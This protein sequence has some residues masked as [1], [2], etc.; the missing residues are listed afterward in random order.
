[1]KKKVFDLRLYTEA[2]RQLRSFVIFSLLPLLFSACYPSLH[3]ISI[4][5]TM[6][7]TSELRAEYLPSYM[8]AV[9]L[10]PYLPHL[11]LLIAP[12]LTFR[13]FSFLNVKSGRRIA[14]IQDRPASRTSMRSWSGGSTRRSAWQ[15]LRQSRSS[16]PSSYP[17]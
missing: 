7:N 15:L 8:T 2:L 6:F 10:H 11:C 12:L 5:T 9:T 13:V 14:A 17:R 16:L 4:W 3:I 1:M